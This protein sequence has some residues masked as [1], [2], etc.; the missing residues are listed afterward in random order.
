[1]IEY[2]FTQQVDY[3][4]ILAG[5]ILASGISSAAYSYICTNGNGPSM[6]V[7]IFFSGPLSDGDQTILNGVMTTYTNPSIGPNAISS[8]LSAINADANLI[9]VLRAKAQQVIPTLP[10]TQLQALCILLGINPNN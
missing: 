7:S 2:D 5:L 1:M 3:P 10:I 8:I 4:S 6:T 9:T